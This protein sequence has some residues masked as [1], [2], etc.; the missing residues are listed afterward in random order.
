MKG[1]TLI[2][3]YTQQK[4]G[5]EMCLNENQ[6]T[7]FTTQSVNS[8]FEQHTHACTGQNGCNAAALN[9]IRLRPAMPVA[10]VEP[11]FTCHT[12]IHFRAYYRHYY[13]V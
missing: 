9:V 5:S 8:L 3:R 10:C 12:C 7:L 4:G 6:Q 11:T 2:I 13:G 1:G